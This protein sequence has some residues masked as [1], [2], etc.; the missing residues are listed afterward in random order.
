MGWGIIRICVHTQAVRHYLG[1]LLTAAIGCLEGKEGLAAARKNWRRVVGGILRMI[2]LDGLN[3][4]RYVT[5][6][7]EVSKFGVSVSVRVA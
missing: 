7:T 3:V 1:R 6:L 4:I 5:K 2:M